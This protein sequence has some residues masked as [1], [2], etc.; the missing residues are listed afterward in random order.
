M[1]LLGAGAA[2]VFGWGM[3]RRLDS[4]S[5]GFGAGFKTLTGID[6][7]LQGGFS[8]KLSRF[9]SYPVTTGGDKQVR[10]LV[11]EFQRLEGVRLD[12]LTQDLE[13]LGQRAAVSARNIAGMREALDARGGQDA[14]L[15]EA[16]LPAG[17]S[18]AQRAKALAEISYTEGMDANAS[19]VQELERELARKER[20]LAEAAALLVLKNKAHAIWG[21]A[22][23]ITPPKSGR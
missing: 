7:G 19:R 17:M 10:A 16:G 6:L 15:A 11:A 21:D 5:E 8:G 14:A 4:M 12:K 1:G 22:D 3:G 13:R 2:A 20:A 23:D 18:Q 9:M